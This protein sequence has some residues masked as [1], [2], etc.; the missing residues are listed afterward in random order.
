MPKITLILLKK[1]RFQNI[2]FKFLIPKYTLN[3]TILERY[4]NYTL[5]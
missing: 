4:E 2:L 5:L 3:Y 1:L